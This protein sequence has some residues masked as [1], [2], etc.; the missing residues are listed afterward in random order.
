MLVLFIV[1]TSLSGWG[2]SQPKQCFA[3]TVEQLA[4][5][6]SDKGIQASYQQ[7]S[8]LSKVVATEPNPVL[9]ILSV[10]PLGNRADVQPDDARFLVKMACNVR[11]HCLPFYV[12][13]RLPEEAAKHP[14]N[15][16]SAFQT[17]G[18]LSLKPN[19]VFT[20]RSGAHATLV[21]DDERAHIEVAVVSLQNGMVGQKIRVASQNHKQIYVAEVVSANL[22]KRSF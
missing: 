5:T 6:L 19:S 4:Q 7:V 8:L 3:L 12:V 18:N 21:M 14:A 10:E 13:V 9:D 22:L 16:F 2:Q 1:A 15:S 17:L 20:I 11:S